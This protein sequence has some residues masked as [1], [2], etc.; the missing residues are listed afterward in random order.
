MV[1]IGL[2]GHRMLDASHGCHRG[3]SQ[4]DLLRSIMCGSGRKI[5]WFCVVQVFHADTEKP[6][7][8][9]SGGFFT[10]NFTLCDVSFWFLVLVPSEGLRHSGHVMLGVPAP[11]SSAS[12]LAS[13]SVMGCDVM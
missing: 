5:V 13:T 8:G 12:L 9:D 4:H 1:V 7:F 10:K 6:V 2:R 3:T 11:V